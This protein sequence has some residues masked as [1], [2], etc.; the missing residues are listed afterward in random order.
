MKVTPRAQRHADR[1]GDP[2]DGLVNMFDLGLVL[3]VAFLLAA[4]QSLDLTD[5]LTRR[6]VTLIRQTP[7]GQAI[8]VKRGDQLK[9]LELSRRSAAGTGA[10][11]GSVYRLADGRL[12][13][14]TGR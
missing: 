10:R 9:T 8:I 5:L 12:V 2:L 3:A 13:Y 4:L 11:V 7:S 1:A 6:A 14:V